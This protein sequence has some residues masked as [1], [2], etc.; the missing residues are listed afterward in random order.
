MLELDGPDEGIAAT[1]LIVGRRGHPYIE[2]RWPGGSARACWDTGAS[3][4]VV[5]VAFWRRHPGLFEEVG[6]SA[7][8][9]S[10][11]AQADTPLLRMAAPRIGGRL[12]RRT[13]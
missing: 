8:T 10:S 6:A 5:D 12:L 9:D 4:T 11:G 3:A 13:R 7:G 1:E 2:L